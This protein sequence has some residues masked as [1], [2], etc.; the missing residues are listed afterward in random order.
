[1]KYFEYSDNFEKNKRINSKIK[2]SNNSS[3]V[4]LIFEILGF[5][6]CIFG[7]LQFWPQPIVTTFKIHKLQRYLWKYNKQLLFKGFVLAINFFGNQIDVKILKK[8][9]NVDNYI[10]KTSMNFKR[11]SHSFVA[12]PS[13]TD[14]KNTI[15]T[16]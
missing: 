14:F 8:I 12:V 7:R 11:E 9:N 4:I 10:V 15:R 13:L 2:I 5:R 3:F 6:N 1:M 16:K